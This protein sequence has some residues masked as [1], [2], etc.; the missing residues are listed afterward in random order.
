MPEADE[1]SP[2]RMLYAAHF[3]QCEVIYHQYQH[4]KPM[5]FNPIT[6]QQVGSTFIAYTH[7]WMAL[8]Y[9]VAEGFKEIGLQDAELDQLIDV[10]L[11]ELRVFRN[12]VFHFQKTDKKRAQFH[13]VDQFNWAQKLHVAFQR[14]FATQQIV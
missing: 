5:F 11:D 8:L 6:Q 13:G 7:I 10:H 4:T 1:V 9:V 14:F 12:S 3:V 2:V